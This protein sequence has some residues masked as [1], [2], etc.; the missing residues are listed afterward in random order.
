MLEERLFALT[1]RLMEA[2]GCPMEIM[3]E[4][5]APAFPTAIP[6]VKAASPCTFHTGRAFEPCLGCGWSLGGHYEA[7]PIPREG[8]T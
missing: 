5:P 4:I 8:G 6:S 3:T 7:Q 1:E 2:Y